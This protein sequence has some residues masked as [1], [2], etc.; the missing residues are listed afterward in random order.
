MNE[1]TLRIIQT[2]L[3]GSSIRSR[4]APPL[5]TPVP[6]RGLTPSMPRQYVGQ[7]LPA[8]YRFAR[9][10]YDGDHWQ[11]GWGWAGPVPLPNEAQQYV[12]S[13]IATGFVSRN[14][15]RA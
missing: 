6:V 10:M 2:Q 1:A 13:L 3:L 11:G 14:V 12:W 7:T 15:L 5:P 9:A 4:F 8:D